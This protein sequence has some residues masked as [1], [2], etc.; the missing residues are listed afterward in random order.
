MVAVPQML[1]TVLG[2]LIT[3][4]PPLVAQHDHDSPYAGYQDRDIKAFSDGDIAA[5]LA[6]DGMGF[7]LA[8][9]LNHYPGPKHVLEMAHGLE[10]SDEQAARIRT[11]GERMSAEAA[12][13][14][15]TL[16]A[17]ERVLDRAFASRDIDAERLGTLTGEIA[18]LR[19]ELRA[20]HLGAHL[21]VTA[22]LTE[23]QIAQYDQ[24]RGYQ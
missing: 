14:G 1:A 22:A 10:L 20:V 23:A 8:A 12:S 15:A 3:V 19:G 2:L 17:R 9:E 6:G 13:L 7:A 24:L 18:A 4:V 11:I 5:L 21:E 16:V